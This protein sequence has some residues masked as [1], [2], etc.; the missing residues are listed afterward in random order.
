MR[1]QFKKDA[2]GREL[3]SGRNGIIAGIGNAARSVFGELVV[4]ELEE[5]D[6]RP[7]A[8][9]GI[10]PGFDPGNGLHEGEI[11][12]ER[13]GGAFDF[14]DG[15]ADWNIF[16]RSQYGIRRFLL[17]RNFG[18]SVISEIREILL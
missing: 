14:L 11:K 4:A 13:M 12:T 8:L 15:R 1:V 18:I 3:V 16:E 5:A 6:I 17:G 7:G 9:L 10:E 2:F